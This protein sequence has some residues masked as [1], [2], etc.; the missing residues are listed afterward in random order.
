MS[1]PVPQP[2]QRQVQ[3]DHRVTSM[4]ILTKLVERGDT[5]LA[6]D[7]ARILQALW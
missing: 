5:E 6:A 3:D 2:Q 7:I 1:G 4:M